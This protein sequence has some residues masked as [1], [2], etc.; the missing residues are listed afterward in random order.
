MF[1]LKEFCREHC[2]ASLLDK[3]IKSWQE[4]HQ[5]Y[6][7]H[8]HRLKSNREISLLIIFSRNFRMKT[9]LLLLQK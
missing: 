5:T 2:Y 9:F 8:V 6:V 7:A 4:M 3:R 1:P